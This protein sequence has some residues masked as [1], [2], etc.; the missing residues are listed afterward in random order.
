MDGCRGHLGRNAL[1]ESFNV[2]LKRE[3]LQDVACWPEV[4]ICGRELFKWLTRYNTKR[5]HSWCH[6]QS[7][8]AYE[9]SYTVML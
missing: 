3:I 6:Y 8:I 4:L 9:T 2:S 7:S 5:R 1:A